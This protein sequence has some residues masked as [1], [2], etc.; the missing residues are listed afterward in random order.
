MDY[1]E[2]LSQAQQTIVQLNQAAV[3]LTEQHPMQS[4]IAIGA[5]GVAFIWLLTILMKVN[6][7]GQGSVDLDRRVLKNDRK[8]DIDEVREEAKRRL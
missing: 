4:G 1:E 3:Q 5:L 2:F 8:R 6:K 7:T